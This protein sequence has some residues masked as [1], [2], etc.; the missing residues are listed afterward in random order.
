METMPGPVTEEALPKKEIVTT[1]NKARESSVDVGS[2]VLLLLLGTV[3]VTP[4]PLVMAV[5]LTA[6]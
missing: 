5:T 2:W 1:V 4:S 6:R 3:E